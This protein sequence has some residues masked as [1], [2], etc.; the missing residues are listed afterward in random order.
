M[1]LIAAR[2]TSRVSGGR[3]R[4]GFD[5]LGMSFRSCAHSARGGMWENFREPGAVSIF[6]IV[7]NF[8]HFWR[9]VGAGPLVGTAYSTKGQVADKNLPD[10]SSAGKP[11]PAPDQRDWSPVGRGQMGRP[12]AEPGTQV[13]KRDVSAKSPRFQINATR[14]PE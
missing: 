11:S 1:R 8:A 12:A 7:S 9:W 10:V 14:C 3:L 4:S 6:S 13:F 2:T 5:F